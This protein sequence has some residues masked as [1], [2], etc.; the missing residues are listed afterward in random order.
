MRT[1]IWGENGL[2]TTVKVKEGVA[3]IEGDARFLDQFR[4]VTLV[5]SEQ[6]ELEE[7]EWFLEDGEDHYED[8]GSW[9]SS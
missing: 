4:V 5:T 8:R 1:E 2:N 6:G 7:R 3:V 9:C